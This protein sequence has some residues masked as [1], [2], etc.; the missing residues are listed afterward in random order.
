MLPAPNDPPR[1]GEVWI[2]AGREYRVERIAGESVRIARV[3]DPA[4]WARLS[5]KQFAS[6]QMRKDD[7]S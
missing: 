7:S 1:I 4:F 2:W 5:L 3:D 6:S